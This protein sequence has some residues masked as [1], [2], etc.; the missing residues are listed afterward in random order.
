M[1]PLALLLLVILFWKEGRGQTSHYTT[2]EGYLFNV[3]ARYILLPE[4]T[5]GVAVFQVTKRD[6]VLYVQTVYNSLASYTPLN[7]ENLKDRENRLPD[8]YT[9]IVP[10]HFYFDARDGFP[11][12]PPRKEVLVKAGQRINKL[13]KKF[14]VTEPMKLVV[15]GLVYQTDMKE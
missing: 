3:L 14:M 7:R 5:T 15:S 4:D 6:G 12:R 8:G 13:K 10:V 1:K 2:D 9:R 11:E